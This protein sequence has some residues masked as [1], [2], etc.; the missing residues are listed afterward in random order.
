MIPTR[1]MQRRDSASTRITCVGVGE[2]GWVDAPG[3]ERHPAAVRRCTAGHAEGGWPAGVPVGR[4][5]TEGV[6]CARCDGREEDRAQEPLKGIGRGRGFTVPPSKGPRIE[7]RG[8][9]SSRPGRGKPA[10]LVVCDS[11]S[12]E[13]A[14]GSDGAGGGGGGRG[15]RQSSGHRGDAQASGFKSLIPKGRGSQRVTRGCL[16]VLPPGRARENKG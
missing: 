4:R 5:A 6:S 3:A 14:A 7:A 13:G 9:R 15:G 10:M 12:L 16:A 8:G 1:A 2:M 11:E